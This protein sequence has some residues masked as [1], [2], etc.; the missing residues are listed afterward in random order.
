MKRIVIVLII[1]IF[2]F[3]ANCDA[4]VFDS[5][6]IH[7]TTK[8]YLKI[9]IIDS[10]KYKLNPS[11]SIYVTTYFHDSSLYISIKNSVFLPKTV[12]IGEY[13]GSDSINYI[14][15]LEVSIPQVKVCLEG[16]CDNNISRNQLPQ[17]RTASICSTFDSIEII[18]FNLYIPTRKG[19]SSFQII[20]NKI[21]EH[22]RHLIMALK[23]ADYILIDNVK[24]KTPKDGIRTIEGTNYMIEK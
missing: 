4:Q 15:F 11:S 13:L 22:C 20:G 6:R 9:Q 3:N 7:T 21:P 16:I 2:R 18:Q 5:V 24:V 14:D 17:I 19:Y 10:N 23:E 1:L 8:S 12:F